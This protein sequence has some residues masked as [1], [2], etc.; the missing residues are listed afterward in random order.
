MPTS[1]RFSF[2]AIE[3]ELQAMKVISRPF[4]EP[5]SEGIFDSLVNN[6]RAI[7]SAGSGDWT[8]SVDEVLRTIPTK[9]HEKNEKATH[10]IFGELSW[11][12][13]LTA[14]KQNK[15]RGTPST[16]QVTG[17]ASAHVQIKR[18]LDGQV[19]AAWRAELG[20]FDSPGCY[21]HSHINE[22]VCVPRVPTLFITPMDTFE[23]L[24]G[25]LFQE[26]WPEHATSERHDVAFWRSKQSKL[27]SEL[28]E[29]KRKKVVDATGSPWVALKK[30]KPEEDDRLFSQQR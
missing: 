23:F 5:S 30:A 22:L 14:D 10:S 18:H 21:F 6:L 29:W 4:M 25:E 9:E 11:V 27:L 24:L 2:D 1:L 13:G 17:V 3:A 28:L 15:K 7:K 12:W 20:A 16:F 26:R 8:V 19:L